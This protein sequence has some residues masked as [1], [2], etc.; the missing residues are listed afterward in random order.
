VAPSPIL[1]GAKPFVFEE[2][3]SGDV[4]IAID[5]SG[6]ESIVSMGSRDP[7]LESYAGYWPF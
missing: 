5:A 3:F 2:A 1:V 6:I 4:L 7:G